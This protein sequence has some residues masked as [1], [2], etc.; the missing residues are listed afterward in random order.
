VLTTGLGSGESISRSGRLTSDM[1]GYEG[2][3]VPC[4]FT[5]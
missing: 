3:F 4:S 5:E 1:R 2:G